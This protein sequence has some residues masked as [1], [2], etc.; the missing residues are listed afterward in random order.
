MASTSGI[1][2]RVSTV[3]NARADR[4]WD[5]VRHIASHVEWMKDA[6]SI[7][8]DDDNNP[9]SDP[10]SDG[11]SDGPDDASENAA[12]DPAD[13]PRREGVGVRFSCRTKVGP[14]VLN[15]R[16]EVTE[17]TEGRLIGI[18][19]QGLVT[20]EG[21]LQI[22]PIDDT[23]TEVVWEEQLLFPARMGGPIGARLARPILRRIWTSNLTRLAARFR[24]AGRAT[25]PRPKWNQ[26]PKRPQSPRT[27]Q[28]PPSPK[29]A[30]EPAPR[31]TTPSP[32]R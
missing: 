28:P 30:A 3:I 25:G 1:S 12:V 23:R 4:V 21:R 10:R 20:G 24:T 8:F 5:D 19:H 13:D 29:P 14:I 27:A 6:V 11:S 26:G 18:R 15:D 17:W 31:T 7:K 9:A 32:R 2:I 22:N 16:M